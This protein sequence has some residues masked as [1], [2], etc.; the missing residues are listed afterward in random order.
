MSYKHNK[1][2][3]QAHCQM[4]DFIK[5]VIETI[6]YIG[7]AFLMIIENIFPPIPS[8][9][10]MPFAGFLTTNGKLSFSGIL[11]AG[12]TGSI[13][14]TLPFYYLGYRIGK[15][16][17]LDWADDHGHWLMITGDDIERAS[18]WFRRHGKTAVLFC[19]LIPGIRTLISVPAGVHRMNLLTYLLLTT[20][21]TTLWV[22][23]L[24]YLGQYLKQN[25]SVV[26]H[27]LDP[28][29]YVVIGGLVLW[30]AGH[31]IRRKFIPAD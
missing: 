18:D 25:Y 9:V 5:A 14:G 22:G 12:V 30:Y 28:V 3:T 21:G 1:M 2:F 19:R 24:A 27:Y 29:S 13:A 15:D 20:V 8:E 31:V 7:V 10:I 11:I 23:L 16:R 6:G 17:L 26:S 4:L